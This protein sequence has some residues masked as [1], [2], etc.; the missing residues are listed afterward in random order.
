MR[1]YQVTIVFNPEAKIAGEVKEIKEFVTSSGATV[2]R[3]EDLA[4]KRLSYEIAGHLEG[5]FYEMIVSGPSDLT[6]KLAESLRI[7]SE[8]IRFLIRLHTEEPTKLD[9]AAEMKSK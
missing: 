3:E 7:N 1:K 2:E 9:P 6:A 8:V 5:A 4:T